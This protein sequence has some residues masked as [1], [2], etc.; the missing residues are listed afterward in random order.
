MARN[1]KHQK[2]RHTTVE[3]FRPTA[4]PAQAAAM[5]DLRRSSAASK[6]DSRPARLRTRAG[7]KRAA[8]REY[9]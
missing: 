3:G 6:H 8:V 9:A 7:V 2:A 4:N 1:R 5:R